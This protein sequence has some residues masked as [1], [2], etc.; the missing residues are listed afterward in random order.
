[1]NK[2][3]IYHSCGENWCYAY[4]ENTLHIRLQTAADDIDLVEIVSADPFEA[5]YLNHRM[6]RWKSEVQPMTR[7]GSDG[8]HDY[9]EIFIT[10]PYKRLKYWFI[11]HKGGKTWEYG[12]K[13]IVD[14]VNRE[15]VW[16][17]FIFPYLHKSEVYR[18]P[19]WVGGT[20]W[21]QIFPERY[22]NGNPELNPENIKEWKDG[23]KEVSNREFYGGDLPGIT[24]KLDH[25]ARA[26]FNGIY[27]TPIF[28]ST[29]VHKYN[30][31]DYM[32]IDPAFGTE[33][34]LRT[35]VRECHKRG[36]RIILDAVFNHS[37]ND[38][39]PWLDVAKNGEKSAYKDWFVI[40]GFPL[41]KRERTPEM[42]MTQESTL[43]PLPP[44]CR[45]S[46]PRT[47]KSGTFF[48]ALQ[49]II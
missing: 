28:D 18:A 13:G 34:D 46:T 40:D 37:G 49:S 10:L 16:N 7:A 41:F 30:T 48:S 12:E 29:S 22:Y 23:Y 38:F 9:W 43:L 35:L 27:L 39:A 47:P 11:L 31:R 44:G 42:P 25:I 32:K 1:M 21:Y 2:A 8:V 26:G 24:A 45:N 3:G 36:I 6:Y 20:V 14:T 19:D 5:E 17:T 33:E 15:N 4:D